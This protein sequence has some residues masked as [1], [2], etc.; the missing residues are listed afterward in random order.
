MAILREISLNN[1]QILRDTAY[2]GSED[3]FEK[4]C[5]SKEKITLERKDAIGKDTRI[6]HLHTNSIAYYAFAKKD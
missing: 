2:A 1:G 5:L 6:I 4:A 3:E